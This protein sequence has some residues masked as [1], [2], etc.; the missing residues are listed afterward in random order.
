MSGIRLGD[1]PDM[2]KIV[3]LG[4]ELLEQSVYKDIK[5]DVLKFR[6]L[7]GDMMLSKS[8]R[9]F[10]IVDDNDEP[11]GFLLGMV[12]EL[13]FS[14]DRYGTDVAVYVRD[15]FKNHAPEMFQQFIDWAKSKPRVKEIKLGISSGMDGKDRTGKFYESMGF[16]NIGG[17]YLMRVQP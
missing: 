9:V 15:G 1:L 2:G 3:D 13:F 10:V 17:L 11:Q 14:R 4:L 6:K 5:P 8:G 7:V 16:D 12:S